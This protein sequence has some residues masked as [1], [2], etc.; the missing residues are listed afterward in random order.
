[1][2]VI[3]ADCTVDYSGR[4]DTHLPE[5][6]RL[7]LVK[8]DG[9]VVIHSDQGASSLNWM[10]APNHL[11]EQDNRWVVTNSKGEQLVIDFLDVHLDTVTAMGEEPGLEKDGVES[12]LQQLLAVRPGMIEDGLTLIR[13]EFPTAIGPVD[14]LCRDNSGTTVAVEIKRRGEIDAVEQLGR[15]VAFLNRDDRLSPV[16]G[17]L[18]AQQV[19]PQAR[20]LAEDRN[21]GWVEVDYDELREA[22]S[23]ALKLF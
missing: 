16:R 15:Y 4:L 13:R 23:T 18:V 12:E 11:V 5:A 8:A 3:V 6:T 20:T 10:S 14:L 7:I 19:R 22:E 2:R 17:L 9:T 1:M 21:L